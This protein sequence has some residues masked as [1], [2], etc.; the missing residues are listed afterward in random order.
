MNVETTPELIL[1]AAEKCPQAKETLKTLFPKVFEDERSLGN[2]KWDGSK[3][4][5]GLRSDDY[6]LLVWYATSVAKDSL[7]LSDNY[8]WEVTLG[9]LGGQYLTPTRK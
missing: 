5:P 3:N 1:A 8:K 4:Q 2:V 6:G 9:K 7:C